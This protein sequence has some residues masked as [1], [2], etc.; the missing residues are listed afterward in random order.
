MKPRQRN[1]I[2]GGGFKH[3]L[4][5]PLPGEIIQFDE[6]IFQMGWFNHQPENIG[7]KDSIFQSF[8]KGFETETSKN[9]LSSRGVMIATPPVAVFY[10]TVT[11]VKDTLD[12]AEPAGQC[13]RKRIACGLS[14]GKMGTV[15]C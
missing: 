3:F 13:V 6:H 8:M 7:G 2:L 11:G 9:H 14:D 12:P 15:N 1:C 5:L 10:R 4:F